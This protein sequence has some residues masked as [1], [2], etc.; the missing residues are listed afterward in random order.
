MRKTKKSQFFK[1]LCFGWK[2][3][4]VPKK[5]SGSMGRNMASLQVHLCIVFGAGWMATQSRS[6]FNCNGYCC[7]TSPISSNGFHWTGVSTLPFFWVDQRMQMNGDF[8]GF[9]ENN[10]ALFGLV[11]YETVEIPSR[12]L[13]R[14]RYQP[15][16]LS[17]WL[18]FSCLV[19]C[20]TVP[21]R[22]SWI[23]LTNSN[24]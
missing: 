21:W 16:L 20:V 23:E 8:E 13:S 7:W 15:A 6:G 9:P 19:G 5:I 22:V 18:C 24:R 14:V 17:R 1:P 12:E 4:S 3:P 2:L 11:S 10:S